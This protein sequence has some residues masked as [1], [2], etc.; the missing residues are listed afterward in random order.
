MHPLLIL[1]LL[2]STPATAEP[3]DTAYGTAVR[4]I[5][6]MYLQPDTVDEADLLRSAAEGLAN[7]VHWLM[8]EPQGT[9]VDLRHGS[10]APIGSVS[11]A[12]MDTLP[13]ALAALEA[14]VEDSGYPLDDVDVRLRI[15]KGMTDALDRYSRVLA[16]DPLSR[17]DTRLK[18][19]LMG[20]GITLELVDE[21]M[22]VQ[23]LIRGGPAELGGVKVD[24]VLLRIDGRSTTNMP[25][26]EA[27][28]IIRGEKDTQVTLSVLRAGEKREVVLTRDEVTVPNVRHRT[29]DGNIGYIKITHISQRT[30]HNLVGALEELRA[31]GALSRGLVL[32]LRGNTGGSM[33]EA[34]RSADEFLRSGLLLTTE[35]PD[36]GQVRNLQGEMR[37]IDAGTEPQVPLAVVVDERTASGSEILAGALLE[38]DRAALVGS[39]TY[40]KGTVQKIYT[41][42]PDTR[43]KLTV[44]QY[45]LAHDRVIT[46]VGLV[47]DVVVGAIELDAYGVR[48]RGWDEGFQRTPWDRILPEVVEHEGWRAEAD[49]GG[50][51]ALELARRAVLGAEAPTRE[52]TLASLNRE[53]ALLRVEEEGHLV[54]ALEHHQVNWS[55]APEEG[56]FIEGRVS[57][58]ATPIPDEPD[59]LLVE[60]EVTNLGDEPLARTLVELECSSLRLWSGLVVP[61]G[62]VAPHSKQKGQ[63]RVALPP[64][65]DTREDLV[66]VRLRADQRPPLLVGDELLRARS[67]PTPRLKVAARM[68]PHGTEPG[69]SGHPQMR[70]EITVHNLAREP[71]TGLEV[72]FGYP[73]DLDLEL[74]DRAAGTPVLAGG[75]SRRFD[76]V[77]ELGPTAPPR[78][79]LDLVVTSERHDELAEWPL[80]LPTDGTTV[81]L[82]APEVTTRRPVVSAPVGPLQLPLVVHDDGRLDHVVVKANGRKVAWAAGG[83]GRVELTAEVNLYAGTNWVV[84]YAEDDLGIVTRRPL[85]IYG[86]PAASVDAEGEED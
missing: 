28:R 79:P 55:P 8:V 40:G 47:P 64:G 65:I 54:S 56:T 83:S 67:S 32:D 52:A 62:W 6:T 71:I 24:D 19:T 41:L 10:G 84:V 14:L 77:M 20:V 48:Y 4:L 33:K 51:L 86:E 73:G 21:R 58:R 78:L 36:G 29:L 27:E 70:A 1:T 18:G 69:A 75:K 80:G 42:D 3:A 34:A 38:L 57:V 59:V 22:T 43:L 76:L 45:L 61:V 66:S 25:M 49:D 63:V 17:F 53:A 23:S 50:D 15:L 37:A 72:H 11:V 9:S 5:D 74:V 46:D 16:G 44:A 30:V 31:V 26:S 60:A 35:G 7:N 2:G 39:R 13:E 81:V 68:V 12:S 85:A 82:Q